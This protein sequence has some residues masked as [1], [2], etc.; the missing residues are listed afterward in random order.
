M[1][2]LGCQEKKPKIINI[3][4]THP[5]NKKYTV[6]NICLFVL[7]YASINRRQQQRKIT[8]AAK[9]LK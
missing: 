8:I 1:Q 4:L 3:W 6:T 5:I 2:R 9:R 7:N